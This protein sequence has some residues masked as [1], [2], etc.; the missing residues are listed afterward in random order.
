MSSSMPEASA[1]SIQRRCRL[2]KCYYSLTA[3]LYS[4]SS[5]PSHQ[6][7]Q[8]SPEEKPQLSENTP[9]EVLSSTHR[10]LQL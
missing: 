5:L 7:G 4:T 1:G 10:E 2:S 8:K 9:Q 6:K 3:L